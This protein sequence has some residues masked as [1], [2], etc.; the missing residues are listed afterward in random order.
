MKTAKKF[1]CVEM[2]AE[3]QKRL[4]REISDCGPEEA[5]KR[6]SERLEHD[7]VLSDFL[8]K[9]AASMRKPEKGAA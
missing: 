6:R 7:P 5:R 3:I 2:K 8:R 1:D 4:M 9:K